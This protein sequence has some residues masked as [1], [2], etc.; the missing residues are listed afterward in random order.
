VLDHPY[1][2]A[3]F[4]ADDN[5]GDEVD[6]AGTNWNVWPVLFDTFESRRV[7][8]VTQDMLDVF[9]EACPDFVPARIDTTQVFP[10]AERVIDIP[11]HGWRELAISGEGNTVMIR[12]APRSRSI[13]DDWGDQTLPAQGDQVLPATGPGTVN[14]R[15]RQ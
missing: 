12:P 15:K 13:S 6:G 9:E 2:P 7:L 4:N 11:S 14:V 5:N 3:G 10:P 1:L 8:I